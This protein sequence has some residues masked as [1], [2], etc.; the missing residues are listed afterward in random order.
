MK[1]CFA[2]GCFDIL[3][4]GHIRLLKFAKSCGDYLIVGLNSDRSIRTL[5]GDDRPIICEEERKEMLEAIRW[6]DEVI[7]FDEPNPLS[8]IKRVKPDILIKGD[9]WKGKRVIGEEI[10]N[11][12]RFYPHQGNSTTNIVEII[13]GK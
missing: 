2:N 7:I 6:V 9:D 1:V 10:V 5:K 4:T 3:H 13:K 8:L 11:E 12:V